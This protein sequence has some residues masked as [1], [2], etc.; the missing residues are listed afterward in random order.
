VRFTFAIP[1]GK[2][3]VQCPMLAF[4][5]LLPP[6]SFILVLRRFRFNAF[7]FLTL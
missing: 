4:L 5:R 1:T 7:T 2:V 3:P 6:Q